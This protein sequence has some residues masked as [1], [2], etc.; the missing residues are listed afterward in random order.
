MPGTFSQI[1]VQYVF[2]VKGRENCILPSF[3]T[4]LYKYI[5]GI[6]TNKEQKSLAV[7]GMS[8]HVHV[9]VGLKPSMRIADLVRDIKN[10]STNF[11]NEN[12]FLRNKFSWQEGYG[13]FSYS[14]SGFGK[15]IEYIKNQKE[16][17]KKR[18]FKQEYM[19]FLKKFDISFEDKYLFEF[20][21]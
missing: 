17:H 16:H 10:N 2:A 15:V 11:I 14:Q 6:I 1:Y 19:A 7:N 21:D 13:V 3:Q 20:Y 8:D 4:E 9:L 18:T 5:S 12:K